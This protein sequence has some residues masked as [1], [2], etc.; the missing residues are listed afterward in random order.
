MERGYVFLSY[1]RNDDEL[2]VKRLYQDLVAQGQDVWWD[3]KAMESR[4]RTFLQEIREAIAAADRVIAVVGPNAVSSDY[5][6]YEWEHALLYCRGLVP[7]LKKGDHSLLPDYLKNLHCPDFR[8]ESTYG[9]GIE[10]LLRILQTPVPQLGQVRGTPAL[11][12]HF[13]PRRDELMRL[14]QILFKDIHRP[15]LITSANQTTAM[16]GM[17][18][19]G[20]SVLAAAFARAVDTRRACPD[21]II[22]ITAGKDP[23]ELTIINNLKLIGV[24]FND[25]PKYYIDVGTAR[26][27]IAEVLADKIC[28]IVLDDVWDVKFTEPF[29]NAL[30]PRCR[31]LITTRDASLSSVLGAEQLS[32]D[33]LRDEDALNLLARSSGHATYQL[34]AVAKQIAEECGNLPLALAMVGAMVKDKPDHWEIVFRRLQNAD[35]E[36]IKV[37]FPNYP[38]PNLLKA[39]QV[40][41]DALEEN[42]QS[43]YLELAVFPKNTEIPEKALQTLWGLAGLDEDDVTDLVGLLVNRSLASRNKVEHIMLHDLQHDFV[44]KQ[45]RDLPNLNQ[46]L[47]DAYKNCCTD[48]W[49]TGPNDGYFFEHLAYHLKESGRKDELEQLLCQWYWLQKKLDATSVASLLSDFNYIDHREDLYII[50][51]AIRL[52]AHVLANDTTLLASQVHG[53]LLECSVGKVYEFIKHVEEHAKGPW[54]RCLVPSLI[55]PDGPLRAIL[56]GHTGMVMKVVVTPNSRFGVSSSHDDTLRVW[57]LRTGEEYK[58]LPVHQLVLKALAVTPDGKFVIFG[59]DNQPLRKWNIE[60]DEVEKEFEGESGE[61]V[62][63]T[64][65]GRFVI[66][67]SQIWDIESGEVV[68][69]F[70]GQAK[71]GQSAITPDGRLSISGSRDHTLIVWSIETGEELRTLKGHKDYVQAVAVTPDG[72]LAISGSLDHTLKVWNIETGEELRTLKGHKDYVQ[73]IAVTPDG[74]LAISGSRDKTLKI[75]ELSENLSGEELHTYYGHSSGVSGVAI[76]PDGEFVISSSHDFTLKIWSINATNKKLRVPMHSGWVTGLALSERRG[77]AVSS[78]ADGTL[79]QWDIKSGKWIRTLNGHCAPVNAVAITPNDTLVI[80]ASNDFKLKAWGIKSGKELQ[81]FSGHANFV[82]DVAVSHDGQL[83]ISASADNYLIAWSLRFNPLFGGIEV[84][85][86]AGHSD[87]V[88]AVAIT[89]NDKLIVSA[90]ADKTL[91]IWE[92]HPKTKSNLNIYHAICTLRGHTD[93]VNSVAITPDGK[94]AISGSDDKTLK[95]WDMESGSLLRTIGGHLDRV[96]AVTITKDGKFAIS[97]SLDRT[98]RVWDITSGN[99]VT[100]FVADHSL[101]SCAVLDKREIIVAGDAG[102]NIHVLKLQMHSRS[103]PK[104]KSSNRLFETLEEWNRILQGSSL[105]ALPAPSW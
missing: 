75:W 51:D 2:F 97:A 104:G 103:R 49:P 100:G 59:G 35:I 101:F 39:I 16:H 96:R 36:K 80:S 23:S 94:R 69:K 67:G 92:L 9:E 85:T 90:S 25:N 22:W 98:L 62:E 56:T 4:G 95:I 64:P 8:E 58:R 17:G 40:S 71:I 11:P 87:S 55:S 10:E 28:L 82:Y 24:S 89:R 30:G 57:D 13:L 78:S 32:L 43:H 18:G 68:R 21:G 48:G 44:C 60:S 72:K 84:S 45:A 5:V 6:K 76:T 3:R 20:K 66:S 93:S 105:A 99:L 47:L 63:I 88:N 86:Y 29:V 65:N 31:L 42:E 46:R 61:G 37:Q 1:A 12:I 91:R 73:A 27:R 53:R 54:L 38:Y 77:L 15:I 79:K 26:S 33:V 14:N 81:Q 102:G 52:S 70:K 41:V 7:I 50:R 19:I 34:P 83:A 74:K